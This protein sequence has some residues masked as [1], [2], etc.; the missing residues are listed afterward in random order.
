MDAA[1]ILDA[2][3][4][5]ILAISRAPDLI[6]DLGEATGGTTVRQGSDRDISWNSRASGEPG[7][8]RGNSMG[9]QALNAEKVPKGVSHCRKWECRR[10]S[11]CAQ[12]MGDCILQYEGHRYGQRFAAPRRRAKGDEWPKSA[13]ILYASSPSSQ[14][15]MM[16]GSP[17][18]VR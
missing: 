13:R 3:R 9:W 2:N 5:L 12:Y 11:P 7:T 17:R 16:T 8:A 4:M 1:N 15:F 10:P 18:T 6:D 14:G